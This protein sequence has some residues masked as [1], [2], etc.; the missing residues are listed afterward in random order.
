MYFFFGGGAGG[1]RICKREDHTEASGVLAKSSDIFP[2]PRPLVSQQCL[3]N[4]ATLGLVLAER[5]GEQL[6]PAGKV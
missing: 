6:R 5:G 3:H 4:G 1:G 2:P